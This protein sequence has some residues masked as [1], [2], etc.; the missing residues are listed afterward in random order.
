[1]VPKDTKAAEDIF[2]SPAPPKTWDT[3]PI[4]PAD[5]PMIYG[6][7]QK[8]MGEIAAIPKGQTNKA[9]GF[10]FRGIDDIYNELHPLLAKHGVFTTSTILNRH[11]A[12]H[13]SKSGSVMVERVLSIRYR[14]YALDG[15]YVDTEVDGEAMDSGDKTSNKAM[16][17]AHKYA[18]LQLFCIP[19]LD[20]EDPD[21]DSP[22]PYAKSPA[23]QQ[24][25][26]PEYIPPIT[27]VATEACHLCGAPTEIKKSATDGREYVRC[28]KCLKP[29]S[30]LRTFVRWLSD[31]PRTP[32]PK[33]SEE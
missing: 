30:S 9:Q 7:I 6:C 25:Y 22:K 1:M 5:P 26:T 24:D 8:I 4:G 17:I 18:F 14:F 21:A 31:P 29:G 33:T 13:V 11:Y 19:T 3:P 27:T 15:S 20:A 10:K 32:K 28:T 12:D 2:S 23:A 16:A